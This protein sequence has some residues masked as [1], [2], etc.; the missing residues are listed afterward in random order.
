M[1]A[2]RL[3]WPALRL[4]AIYDDLL[5][6]RITR[7]LDYNALIVNLADCS[8]WPEI[9]SLSTSGNSRKSLHGLPA[10]SNKGTFCSSG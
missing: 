2:L 4:P 1:L 7:G 8:A 10:T 3:Y 5:H 9:Y 6:I